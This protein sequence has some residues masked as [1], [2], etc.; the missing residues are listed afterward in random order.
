VFLGY[1]YI[2]MLRRVLSWKYV[3]AVVVILGFSVYV[4]RQDQETRDEYEQKC[5]QLNAGA[6]PPSPHYEDCDKGADSAA[7]HLPRW[8]RVFS[9]PE[10]ITTWAILLTLLGIAD[11]T[12]QTKKSAEAALISAKAA[13]G[14]AVPTLVVH[15]FSFINT[16]RE[17]PAA[18]YRQPRIR[19]VLKNYGKSPAFL[20]RY[21]IGYSWGESSPQKFTWYPFE[22]QVID[23]GAS[24]ELREVDLEVAD[25]PPEGVIG[26]LVSGERKLVFSGWISYRD[27]FDSPTRK[28]PIHRELVEYDSDA[29]KMTVMDTSDS[30][31]KLWTDP[32][33]D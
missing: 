26:D 21:A 5:Q 25:S 16:G 2:V 24:Y 23:A 8:Y 3:I 10:G 11:Q 19:L 22:D 28:L 7:R 14:V 12:A 33:E 27:V 20:R 4:A 29:S 13:M 6:V 32:N 18:F 31:L 9:W 1:N 30:G 17:N 15:R